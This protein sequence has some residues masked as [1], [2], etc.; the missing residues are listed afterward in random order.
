MKTLFK[1]FGTLC[2]LALWLAA[3]S[4]QAQLSNIT[5]GAVSTNV[6]SK[7]QF[8]NRANYDSTLGKSIP[9]PYTLVSNLWAWKGDVG[10]GNYGAVGQLR[11]YYLTTNVLFSA[12]S[13]RTNSLTGAAGTGAYVVCEVVSVT[14]PVGGIF[15]FWEKG[16]RWP[17]YTFPVGV[18]PNPSKNKFA[19]SDISLGAGQV[20]G[21]AFGFIRGRRFSVTKP[22]DYTVGFR[23][24][25]TSVNSLSMGPLHTPSDVLTVKFTTGV[26]SSGIAFASPI[27]TSNNVTTFTFRQGGLTNFYIEAS[28]NLAPGSW[29]V[30]AGP[31]MKAPWMGLTTTNLLMTY[32]LTNSGPASPNVY[33]RLRGVPPQ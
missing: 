24:I 29:S 25:D 6:G 17:T 18:T 31:M 13:T 27:V 15:Q 20:D 33:Y 28:T 23:L 4:A 19:L 26:D 2:A 5:A 9:L 21:D 12:L 8:V 32:R 22:G 3:G 30:V 1:P 10:D 7:L 11:P 16:S 14:G